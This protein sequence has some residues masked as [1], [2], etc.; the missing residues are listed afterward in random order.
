[1]R[2]VSF[3]LTALVVLVLITPFTGTGA[4]DLFS[5]GRFVI[6]SGIIDREPVDQIETVPVGTEQIF[7]FLEARDIAEDTFVTFVWFHNDHQVGS[8]QL[9]LQQGSRWRTYAYKNLTEGPGTW[10]V[11]LHDANGHVVATASLTVE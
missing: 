9:E 4:D 10:R 3:Y 2:T 1:M 8:F 5:V 11:E 7:C 6:T